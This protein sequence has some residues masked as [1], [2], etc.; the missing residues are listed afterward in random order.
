MSEIS[1]VIP[2]RNREKMLLRAVESVRNQRHVS[3]PE[4]IV[5]DDSE[6]ENRHLEKRLSD[7]GV[8]YI[9]SGGNKGGGFSR[10]LGIKHA[11]GEFVAFLDDDDLWDENKLRMQLE[12]MRSGNAGLCYTGINVIDIH[13][14]K[15]RY[16]FRNPGSE[17]H[18]RAIM[19]KNFIGPTSSVMV[20]KS[21]IEH[22]GGFDPEL[23]A[24]Q[25][26]DFYIGILR[27]HRAAGIDSPLTFYNDHPMPDKVSGSREFYLQAA[28]HLRE[29]YKSEPYFGLLKR[30]LLEVK[31]MK[32]FRSGQFLRETLKNML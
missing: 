23:K 17:D 15:K 26:Y 12:V 18:F 27:N 1:V 3:A 2:T 7:M 30:Y 16:V 24:L 4:I 20:R 21:I 8:R 22:S 9:C 32:M 6:A 11:S 10:N 29:K 31:I 13:G 28:K 25:D 14:R 19:R 5:I